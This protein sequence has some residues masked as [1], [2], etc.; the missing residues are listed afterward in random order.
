MEELFEE[1]KKSGYRNKFYGKDKKVYPYGLRKKYI[2]I[3]VNMSLP[4]DLLPRYKEITLELF[5][6]ITAE[7]VLMYR[8]NKGY[9]PINKEWIEKKFGLSKRRTGE[10]IA[11][12]KKNRVIDEIMYV[13]K[14]EKMYIVNPKYCMISMFVGAEVMYIFQDDMELSAY[15]LKEV[16]S[17]VKEKRIDEEIRS[18]KNG[19]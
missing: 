14:K 19:R 10:L 13:K 17:I 12:L 3:P 7:Q 8:G 6:Y 5:K 11:S 2:K 9:K 15:A 16:S 18:V 1:M 4:Q